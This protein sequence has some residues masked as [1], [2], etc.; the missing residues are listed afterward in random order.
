[1]AVFTAIATAIIGAIGITGTLATIATA[2]VA[3]GLAIGTAKIL[4]V[5][6]APAAG[7]DPGVK[8]QLPPATDNKVTRLYGRN[9]AGGTIIDAE[10]KNQ[11]K[12][13]KYF[14]I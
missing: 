12:T 14:E 13:M 7:Q 4:G 5:M 1:M 8:V 3:A 10:I 11:N 2:F 6:D 9:F